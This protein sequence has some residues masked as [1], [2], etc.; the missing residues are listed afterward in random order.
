IDQPDVRLVV[1]AEAPG[2]LE[3]YVQQAGRA[4]RDGAPARCVL[5]AAPQD[6]VTQARL[7][8]AA[9]HPGT[10]EGWDALQDYVFG[11]RC[12]ER[13]VIARFAPDAETEPCGRCDVCLDA[14]QV[15]AEVA[16][17]RG[18]LRRSAQAKAAKAERDRAVSLTDEQRDEVVAFVEGLRKPLGKRL[19]AQGLRGGR[20]QRGVRWGVP[21]NPRF[22]ALRGVPEVAILTALDEL[23]A[24]G[25]LAAKGKK[26]PTVWMPEKRVR[27]PRAERPAKAAPTGLAAALRAWRTKEARRR[28][29]K[30]YQVFP[31]ATLQALVE[32]RPSTVAELMAIPGIGPSRVAKFSQALL[33]LVS[34]FPE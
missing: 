18:E 21:D 34:D 9:P 15:A 27:P 28:R 11:T 13:A 31:D 19:V 20:S 30:P 24:E 16:R 10:V 5:L 1:H 33:T 8:G 3:S 6:A 12:R 22:G 23:L 29:W 7:R 32:G 4:G 26:Y 17:V 25:R 14:E 2:T